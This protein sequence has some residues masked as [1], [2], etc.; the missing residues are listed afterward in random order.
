MKVRTQTSGCKSCTWSK[1][2][3]IW[4]YYTM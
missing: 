4:L 1:H 2:F 3:L